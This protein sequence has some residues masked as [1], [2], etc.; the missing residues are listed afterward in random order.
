MTMSNPTGL[1]VADI[2]YES[3]DKVDVEGKKIEISKV[4][5]GSQSV[6]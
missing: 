6:H 4:P 1:H 3:P 2:S 5:L